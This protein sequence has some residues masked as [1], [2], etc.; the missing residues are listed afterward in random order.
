MSKN[1]G[2]AKSKKGTKRSKKK[3]ADRKYIYDRGYNEKVSLEK[4]YEESLKNE[5]PEEK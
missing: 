1:T 2:W 3:K 5:A 4:Q